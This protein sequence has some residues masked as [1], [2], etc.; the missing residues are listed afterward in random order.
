MT[1]LTLQSFAA[2]VD[3]RVVEGPALDATPFRPST[4]SRTLAPGETFVCLRGPNFDGHDFITQALERG[5]I[6]L[7][8]DRAS[9]LP[10]PCGVPAI[11]VGDAKLAYLAGAAAARRLAAAQIIGVTGSNG[12]TTTKEF[13]RHL[14]GGH[15]RV[16]ATPQNENN[17]L[18]VAKICY[19]ALESDA[20]VAI[21]EMGARHPGEIAE[22]VQMAM[23][24]VGILTNVGESHMEFFDD[25]EALATTKFA[26]FDKGAR[27]VLN[28]GDDWSVRLAAARGLESASTWARLPG[29]PHPPGIALEAGVPRDGRVALTLGASHAFAAWHLVGA[30]HLRDALLAAAAAIQSGLSFEHAIEGFGD[31]HL[32]P[33]RFEVHALPGGATIVYDAYNASPTS[34]AHALLA[35]REVPATRRIAVLGSM[36]ELGGESAR[37]HEETGAAAA[38]SAIDRLY[39]GGENAQS[40][41]RGALRAG[42]SRDAVAIYAGND[43]VT[44]R[45][46]CE[47]AAGDAVLLKGSRVQKM[48]EILEAL[49]RDGGKGAIAS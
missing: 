38:R 21:V 9:A 45:L 1:S 48:E 5:A 33:G 39:C 7:V 12:K 29:D 35:F 20:E 30:H 19:A 36:A 28:A 40:L 23:P 14:I 25:R 27:G 6:A 10:T 3:G 4:D 2:L 47:L 32:P 49:L 24:D 22:L 43:D 15:R 11:V 31:L 8:V 46:R 34:V 44:E 41:A 17:E 16:L 13:A 18:G 42:M 37:H 26:L